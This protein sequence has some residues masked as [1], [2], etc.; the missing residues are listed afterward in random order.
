[1]IISSL[2]YPLGF[3]STKLVLNEQILARGLRIGYIF[4]TFWAQLKGQFYGYC[5]PAL[6]NHDTGHHLLFP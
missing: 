1:M 2:A 3:Q 4:T 6:V 5:L